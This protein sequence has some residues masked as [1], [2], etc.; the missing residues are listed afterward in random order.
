MKLIYSCINLWKRF[1]LNSNKYKTCIYVNV[2]KVL[3]QIH[4]KIVSNGQF[5]KQYWHTRIN[6][7][8]LKGR[9]INYTHSSH[10]SHDKQ[11]KASF[12]CLGQTFDFWLRTCSI[13]FRLTKT[14]TA[15]HVFGE[16]LIIFS[17]A[18]R[19]KKNFPSLY[20]AEPWNDCQVFLKVKCSFLLL[21]IC[22]Y[23]F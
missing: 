17:C 10:H 23:E 15:T 3:E 18:S 8:Y 22:I 2:L 6:W 19:W 20:K 21:H 7:R 13:I 12:S 5:C 14:N 9:I 16:V 4:K 11:L 1:N